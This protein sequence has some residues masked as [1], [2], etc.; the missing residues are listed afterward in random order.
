MT[1]SFQACSF[2][3]LGAK[4]PAVRI[5]LL[6]VCDLQGF[7]LADAATGKQDIRRCMHIYRPP[8]VLVG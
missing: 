5:A 3:A 4:R 6:I 7:I 1:T 2:M 8:F